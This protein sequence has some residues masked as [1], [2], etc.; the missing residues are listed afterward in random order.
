MNKKPDVI[1]TPRLCL[2]PIGDNQE[3]AVMDLLTNQEIGRTYMVPDFTSREQVYR[4]YDA[5]RRLSRAEDRFVYGI[6]REETLVGLLNDVGMENGCIE[7]GYVIHPDYKNRGYAT[8]ALAAAMN[9][10]FDMGFSRVR[11]GAFPENLPSIRVMEK[12]GMVR[13]KET[14]TLEYR[15]KTYDCVLYE[16]Q[17]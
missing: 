15:G 17:A 14:E 4:V 5:F 6:Y 12:C 3:K 13:L 1:S 11:T 7:L 9:A 2:G 8:E 10:L 16:K